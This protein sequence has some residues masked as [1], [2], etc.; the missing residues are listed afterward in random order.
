MVNGKKRND[1]MAIAPLKPPKLP[2]ITA[3]PMAPKDR[4]ILPDF[5]P[6][7]DDPLDSVSYNGNPEEDS[8]TELKAAAKS[9]RDR[10]S[11]E[12]A[13]VNDT[14]DTERTITIVCDTRRKKE[15]F[16]DKL[17]LLGI[18]DKYL[19]VL[20]VADVLG[21]TLSTDRPRKWPK[22]KKPDQRLVDL[23]VKPKFSP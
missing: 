19:D 14:L 3:A 20:D 12:Q 1:L 15:E 5:I 2:P 11:I 4:R 21:V 17:G 22:A 16:L 7:P 6:V 8:V 23:A 13:R 10:M 18:G 9:F